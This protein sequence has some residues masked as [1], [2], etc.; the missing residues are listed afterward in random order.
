[1]A[2]TTKEL[3]EYMVVLMASLFPTYSV[4]DN[5]IRQLMPEKVPVIVTGV[6]DGSE[7]DKGMETLAVRIVLTHGAKDA[8]F[9]DGVDP[10]LAIMDWVEADVMTIRNALNQSSIT[11]DGDTVSWESDIGHT[12][13]I[14]WGYDADSTGDMMI[15]YANIDIDVERRVFYTDDITLE[16][17]E[18]ANIEDEVTTA[19]ETVTAQ[20]TIEVST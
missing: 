9:D 16:D 4:F 6:L 18:L 3:R 12:T 5:R 7:D 1:M 13:K 15:A 10:E 19:D 8:D 11:I 17:F 14:S 2:K 20:A